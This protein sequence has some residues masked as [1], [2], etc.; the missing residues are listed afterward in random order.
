[1]EDSNTKEWA[2]PGGFAEIGYSPKKYR[3]RV[4]KEE[5]G[6]TVTV[7]QLLAIFDT[8]TEKIFHKPFNTIKSF[9]DVQSSEVLLS[10]IM[11]LQTAPFAL[12]DLPTLS[13]NGRQKNGLRS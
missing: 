1:M 8:N 12:D 7:D 10:R 13:Q 9:L 2:L 3:K 4:K 5:T 11:K 6:L